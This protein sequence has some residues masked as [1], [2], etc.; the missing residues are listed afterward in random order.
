MANN[1][2]ND[3]KKLFRTGDFCMQRFARINNEILKLKKE[4][5]EIIYK[6]LTRYYCYICPVCGNADRFS[7]EKGNW[8]EK[9][10]NVCNAP[11]FENGEITFNMLKYYIDNKFGINYI[12]H[13]FKI[14]KYDKLK[15]YENNINVKR[16]AAKEKMSHD[17]I[18]ISVL[19]YTYPIGI[20]TIY[21]IYDKVDKKFI[22]L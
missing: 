17:V 21:V 3:P 13:D 22:S 8:N 1:I 20:F 7:M 16:S 4:R 6:H 9:C 15:Y 5:Q 14:I 19:I 18:Y 12:I 2:I 11:L 10:C